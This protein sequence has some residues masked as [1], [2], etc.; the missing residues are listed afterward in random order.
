M[1]V[2]NINIK[3]IHS[4]YQ[5]RM[6]PTAFLNQG[7]RTFI[8]LTDSKSVIGQ[9]G[10]IVKSVYRPGIFKRIFVSDL[11]YG[12]KYITALSMMI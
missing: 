8:S 5:L 7:R 1:Q 10:N 11:E 2:A 9:V 3:E 12:K 4:Y 6:K